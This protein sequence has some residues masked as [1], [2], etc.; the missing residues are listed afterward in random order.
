MARKGEMTTEPMRTTTIAAVAALATA[1]LPAAAEARDPYPK[2]A[3][4]ICRDAVVKAHYSARYYRVQDAMGTR[5]PGRNIRRYGLNG[6]RKIQ[7]QAPAPQLAH[8]QALARPA[9]RA[10]ARRRHELSPGR[11]PYAGGAYSIPS[12]HRDVRIG[13]RLQR[14]EPRPAR[15]AP[16]RSCRRRPP[17]WAATCPRRRGR[18]SARRRSWRRRAAAPGSA[19]ELMRG[20]GGQR[21]RDAELRFMEHLTVAEWLCGS[22]RHISGPRGC[23]RRAPHAR[24]PAARSDA[25]RGQDHGGRAVGALRSRRPQGAEGARRRRL[26]RSRCWRGGRRARGPGR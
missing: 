20:H 21:G 19:A 1:A 10:G 4:T 15:T 9:P 2:S 13:R 7:V 6:K 25:R 14:R 16:T 24:Q 22:R 3:G 11:P 18:I 23:A 26:A 12:R 17:D 5:T 8:V